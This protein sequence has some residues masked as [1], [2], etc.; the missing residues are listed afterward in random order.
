MRLACF[1][2][3]KYIRPA[4]RKDSV[5]V[6]YVAK[7]LVLYSEWRDVGAWKIEQP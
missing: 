1:K 4:Q 7:E 6:H 2:I 3:G 5:H